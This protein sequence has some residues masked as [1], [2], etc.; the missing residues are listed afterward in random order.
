MKKKVLFKNDW[1]STYILN[2]WY[3]VSEETRCKNGQLV[4]VLPWRVKNNEVQ[5]LARFEENLAHGGE[6]KFSDVSIITGG[7]ETKD[8]LYHAQEE[9]AEEAGYHVDRD[10]FRSHGVCKPLK[11]SMSTMNL[12]SVRII[13]KDVRREAKGDGSHGEQGSFCD[14]VDRRTLIIEGKDPYIHTIMMR[15]E[16]G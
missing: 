13:S 7:C 14:W 4:A 9:L 16:N 1:L 5:Y 6:G 10:R 15:M 11:S 12:F 8:I 3:V 2:G